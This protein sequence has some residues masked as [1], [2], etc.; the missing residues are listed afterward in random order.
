M[1]AQLRTHA[2]MDGWPRAS[3]WAGLDWRLCHT[4]CAVVVLQAQLDIEARK[5]ELKKA[6]EIK[7]QN[8]QYEVRAGG[9]QAGTCAGGGSSSSEACGPACQSE[10]GSRQQADAE[11]S[12]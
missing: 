9:R 11:P 3:A 4:V 10:Y 6:K 1:G 5:A 8:E 7:E 12:G 2:C